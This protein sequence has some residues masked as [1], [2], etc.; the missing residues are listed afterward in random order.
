MPTQEC[1]LPRSRHPSTNRTHQLSNRR[2]HRR[3]RLCRGSSGNACAH[4]LRAHCAGRESKSGHRDKRAVRAFR[5]PITKIA[6]TCKGDFDL[7][8]G[9]NGRGGGGAPPPPHPSAAPQ[10]LL[11]G[12]ESSRPPKAHKIKS[13]PR[14]SQ[15][16]DWEEDPE[17]VS[18]PEIA[19]A[20]PCAH[21][22]EV[23]KAFPAE[24]RS[25]VARGGTNAD[26]GPP[27]KAERCSDRLVGRPR[28]R[29][30]FRIRIMRTVN[31][32]RR[33]PRPGAAMRI[34]TGR[35]VKSV[36]TKDVAL[37]VCGSPVQCR[38]MPFI[39]S[40]LARAREMP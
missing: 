3:G 8:T 13:A 11:P 35:A 36:K 23:S 7:G 32:D 16:T 25:R 26:I 27:R 4:L 34:R 1:R 21:S 19:T 24:S 40:S 2:P 22:A 39:A 18:K 38:A 5:V 33:Q 6:F 14:P 17:R 29:P 30:R 9:A 31:E 15:R 37:A 20:R 10:P 12:D 28:P